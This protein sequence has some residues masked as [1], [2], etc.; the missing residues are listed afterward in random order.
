[1]KILNTI[2]LFLLITI[3]LFSQTEKQKDFITV[4]PGEE[5]EAGWL[6][7]VF[8][9]A[10]WRD[11]WTTPFE[12][13]LLNLN[14]FDG[15][16]IPLKRG[17][18]Q[19]TKSLRFKSKNGQI[20]KFR[21]VSKDPSKILPK[22]LQET[23]AD[24]IV[25]DQIS[26]A[27][28]M[29]PFVVSTFLDAVGLIEAKPKLVFLADDA[30]LGEFRKEFGGMLGFIEIHP[31]EGE[32]SEPGF[33]GAIDIKGTYKLLNYLEDKRSQ[34]IN[35]RVFLTARLIDI[36][37]G[38]WDRHMDQWRWAKYSEDEI[39]A[40]YPIPRDRDQVFSKYDGIF[41]FIA[42]YLVPPFNNFGY[43]YPQMED[44]TWN[45]R[46]LDRRVLTELDKSTWDSVATFVQSKITDEVIDAALNE[47]PP[48]S[49]LKSVDELIDKLIS[50]RDKLQNASNEFYNV[51]NRYADVFCSVKN[52][53]VEV[54]RINDKNTEVTVYK[55]DKKSGEKKGIPLFHKIFDN[56]ITIDIRI[57]L[58][59]GDDI[60]V[61]KGVCDFSPLV[62]IIGSN[63]KDVLKDESVVNGY[64]LS[65]TPFHSV[66]S[67]TIFYDSGKKT[68]VHLGAGTVYDNLSE[69]EPK[70]D[71]EKFEPQFL[72][73]GDNWIFIPKIGFNADDGF[74]FGGG[75]QLHKYNFREVPQ[76]YMQELFVSYATRFGKGTVAYRGDFYSLVRNG[77]LNLVIGGT[78]QLITRYFGYGNETTFNSDLEE[79]DFYEVDQSL[80][81]LFPTMFYE[82]NSSITGSIGMSFIRAT[83]SIDSDTLLSGF[84]YGDYGTGRLNPLGIH[85]GVEIEGRDNIEFPKNG[86]F[87][88]LGGS[89]YPAIFNVPEA[90]Y[91]TNIDARGFI[92]HPSIPGVTLALRA[93]GKRVWGQFPFYAGATIGGIKS[94]RGYNQDR[95]SGDA[96]LFGQA[97]LRIFLT[98]LNLI[99]RNK[100]GMNA[101]VETGRVWVTGEDSK[102]WHPSYGLGLWLNYLDGMFVISSYIATSPERTTFAFGLGMGF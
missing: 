34:K 72:D 17:G 39:E 73:R 50:R 11:I 69:P 30:K 52:D 61:V 32:N 71:T 41:P 62:R 10:H 67:K 23:I 40:W 4:I 60:A 19:Q 84:K 86:Y 1:M 95:Y 79:N 20:W 92:T 35:S 26:T 28:P 22:E 78:E 55:R 53:Y 36:L 13:E 14:N 49:Y 101:F 46:H 48:E 77:R 87:I 97:E 88:S 96:A 12:V 47:L 59:D 21:S 6:H 90:F 45:G 24:D 2:S 42:A 8:F 7:E 16:I 93:V 51:V 98:N 80:I 94:V 68:T 85:L 64:F 102:K 15:G 100:F 76:E 74:I 25:Q 66:E 63:G 65:I 75:L 31:T 82:L 44:L 18:G 5:Y 56:D 37:L 58:N 57:H 70:D 83:T 99:L 89:I 29:A 81:T 9:G 54:N 27:N 3:T 91:K 43:D 38:D 33:N